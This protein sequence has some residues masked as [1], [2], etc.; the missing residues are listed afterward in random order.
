MQGFEPFGSFGTFGEDLGQRGEMMFQPAF[1]LKESADGYHLRADL[2]G[3]KASDIDVSVVGNR[4]TIS[5]KREVEERREGETWHAIERNY[6]SFLR[7]V[8]LPEGASVD[9]VKASMVDGVLELTIPKSPDVQPR[10][11]Q[12]STTQ[13]Q[14]DQ[15]S[16]SMAK[17][18]KK[19]NGG[20]ARR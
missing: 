13:K 5:G 14:P 1:D 20:E 7:T 4:L 12:I 19:G 10:R 17:D 16:P 6:G 8:T 18:Q 11:V 15:I 2:P 3:V 9:D